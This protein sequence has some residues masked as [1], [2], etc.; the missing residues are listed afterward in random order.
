[1]SGTGHGPGGERGEESVVG[2]RGRELGPITD[3]RWSP[4]A[5]YRPV[6]THGPRAPST[7]NK[8]AKIQRKATVK[9]TN[10]LRIAGC[11]P[12]ATPCSLSAVSGDDPRCR[13]PCQAATLA[14]GRPGLESRRER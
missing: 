7:D 9:G 11:A 13:A 5:L 14:A 1:M 2:R 8:D 10:A 3:S 4:A 12:L 6:A